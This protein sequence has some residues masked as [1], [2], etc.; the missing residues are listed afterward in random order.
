MIRFI[1][2]VGLPTLIPGLV[3]MLFYKGEIASALLISIAS[4][5][6]FFDFYKHYNLIRSVDGYL[7][8][9]I[10]SA[11][12]ITACLMLIELSPEHNNAKAG[13]VFFIF[14]PCA[15]IANNMI[16]RSKPAKEFKDLYANS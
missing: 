16:L 11:V 8:R 4:S 1:H 3:L 5:F 9:I 2:M 12:M 7:K 6:A 15:L 13:A 10:M 14:F